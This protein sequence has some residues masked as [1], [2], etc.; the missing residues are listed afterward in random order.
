VNISQNARRL[1]HF[2][3]ALIAAALIVG[4]LV[5]NAY[6]NFNIGYPKFIRPVS[7]VFVL[8]GLVLIVPPGIMLSGLYMAGL[9][10]ELRGRES[11]IESNLWLWIYCVVFYTLVFYVIL[12]LRHRRN[13]KGKSTYKKND[14]T[15]LICLL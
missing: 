4:V 12:R 6:V 14:Q 9:K 7:D 13:H 15:S 2:F 5:G 11:F 10:W 3:T 1:R 8:I